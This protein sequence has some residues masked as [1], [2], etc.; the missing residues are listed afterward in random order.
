MHDIIGAVLE[1][2]GD[3][4]TAETSKGAP[5]WMRRLHWAVLIFLTLFAL[6][7]IGL[8]ILSG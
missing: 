3:A 6:L 5:R 7:V 4:A 2:L 8:I 1:F